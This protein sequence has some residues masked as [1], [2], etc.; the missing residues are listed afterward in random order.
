MP[1]DNTTWHTR[2]G[3]FC[4][5]KPLLK[6]KSNIRKFSAY[7]TLILILHIILF[8]LNSTFSFFSCI[9]IKK[10]TSYLRLLKKLPKMVKVIILL[11]L[12]LPNLL[13]CC[14][15]IQKNPGPKYT[16]LKFCHWNLNGLRAH[17]SIKISLLHA[18]IIQNNYDIICLS[19]T[20]LNSSIPTNDDRI[21]IEG[22]NF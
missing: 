10:S 17:D 21:S 19:E 9:A 5:L 1:I 4:I 3:M 20:F 7:F 8:Y 6:S 13:F 16:S 18:Y 12:C 14:G 11:S 2:I 22:Y 15:D